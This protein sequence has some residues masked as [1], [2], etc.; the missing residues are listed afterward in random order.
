LT[1]VKNIKTLNLDNT[2]GEDFYL[3]TG[4]QLLIN[5]NN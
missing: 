2:D 3:E 4:P 1:K 5:D